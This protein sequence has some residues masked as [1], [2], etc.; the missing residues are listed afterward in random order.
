MVSKCP[1]AS[2]PTPRLYFSHGLGFV[3]HTHGDIVFSPATST[4]Q[5]MEKHG[6]SAIF[7]ANNV[8][9]FVEFSFFQV[10]NAGHRIY[11]NHP[12]VV[13]YNYDDMGNVS[14]STYYRLSA[15]TVC[16]MGRLCRA[17]KRYFLVAKPIKASNF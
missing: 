7:T 11:R 8:E 12:I 17:V 3:V 2:I 10:S 1:K 9:L 14:S 16:N 15:N 6:N 13:I 4:R 5:P